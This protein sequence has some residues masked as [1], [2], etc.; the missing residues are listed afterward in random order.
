MDEQGQILTVT[1]VGDAVGG[2]VSLVGTNA[3]FVPEA[4]YNGPAGFSYTVRDNGTTGGEPDSLT[5]TG[6]VSFIITEVN[7]PPIARVSPVG[8]ILEGSVQTVP[9]SVFLANDSPGPANESNQTLTLIAV[10]GAVGGTARI[11]GTNVIVTLDPNFNGPGQFFYTIQD[12]GTTDGKPD[13]KTA[14]ATVTADVIPVND[15]PVANPQSL[16]VAVNGSTAIT[17]K[18]DDGDPEV[19]QVLTFAITAV[20]QHGSISGFNPASGALVYTPATNYTGPDSFQFT[21]TDDAMA[22]EPP[23]LTSE[24]AT[25]SI[26]VNIAAKGPTVTGAT[27]QEGRQTTSG[28]VIT[29]NSAETNTVTHFLITDIKN[30]TLFLN[31][32]VTSVADG[33]FVSVAEGLA[34]LKFTPTAGLYSPGADFGFE[35]QAALSDAGLG[36]SV[37][38]AALITVNPNLDFGDAPAPYPTLLAEDGA[39]HVVLSTGSSLFLGL[40]GPDVEADGQPSASATGDN[41]SGSDDEDGVVLPAKIIAGQNYTVGI[42]VSGFGLINGWIDWN[43]DGDWNDEGEQVF[44]NQAVGA[45]TNFF[46]LPAPCRPFRG[47]EFCA[48][49]AQHAVWVGTGGTGQGR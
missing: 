7:D 36:L 28:L 9:I 27:T 15:P 35:V 40:K 49:P 16:S 24:S 31:N 6:R 23:N 13:F 48:I 32:G 1:G 41:L 29:P 21:V 45:G 37:P 33:T 14:T 25:V 42:V 47:H 5:G 12:N 3:V 2:T 43:R 26:D 22:G 17:L 4:D 34:G 8:G 20:P 18:G 39:R 11:E 44:V 38:M 46:E 19:S 30:G 10:G